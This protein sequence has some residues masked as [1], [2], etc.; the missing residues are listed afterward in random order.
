[1]GTH[2]MFVLESVQTQNF[3]DDGDALTYDYYQTFVKPKPQASADSKEKWVC[4]ICGYVHEG[5]LPSDFICPLCKH[6]ASDFEKIETTAT[7]EK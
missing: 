1:M 4:K 5:P 3:A 7:A 2:T 6:P